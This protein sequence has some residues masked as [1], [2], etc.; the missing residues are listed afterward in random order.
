MFYQLHQLFLTRNGIYLVV[1]NPVRLLRNRK[2]E[3]EGLKFWIGALSIHAPE[4]PIAFIVTRAREVNQ[5]ELKLLDS[6]LCDFCTDHKGLTLVLN[7]QEKL[8]FF[9]VDNSLKRK[10]EKYLAPLKARIHQVVIDE[11]SSGKL[12]GVNVR[13]KLSWIYIMDLFARE[14]K[15]HMLLNEMTYHC[16]RL[17]ITS[18]ELE[19]MLCFYTEVGT[20]IYFPGK[21]KIRT[22]LNEVAVLNPQWLLKALS[23]YIYDSK[24]HKKKKF[25]IKKPYDELLAHYEETGILSRSLLKHLWCNYNKEEVAFLDSLS[26]NM[27]L[28][29]KYVFDAEEVEGAIVD[30]KAYVVPAMLKDYDGEVS[31]VLPDPADSFIASIKFDEP[32]PTG[33]F[34]RFIS[35]FVRKSGQFEGSEEP[36]LYKNYADFGF[37][38]NMVHCVLQKEIK[39]IHIST[40]QKNGEAHMRRVVTFASEVVLRLVD[41]LLGEKFSPR[42]LV[43]AYDENRLVVCE[44]NNLWDVLKSKRKMIVVITQK[45][46]KISVPLETFS[47]FYRNETDI[48]RSTGKYITDHK[49]CVELKEECSGKK[50]E[51]Y[52]FLVHEWGS[53]STGHETHNKV[54][55][56]KE[57]LSRK[58]INL[59]V[60]EAFA[61]VDR[62]Q[63]LLT[64]SNLSKKVVIFLTRRYMERIMDS[65]NDVA[66]QFPYWMNVFPKKDTI[67]IILEESMLNSEIWIGPITDCRS[68]DVCRFDFSTTTRMSRKFRQ[69]SDEFVDVTVLIHESQSNLALLFTWLFEPMQK[70]NCHIQSFDIGKL[71]SCHRAR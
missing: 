7:D 30:A 28:T 44:L 21:N 56:V 57:K 27:L 16:K 50:Y 40:M 58:G 34:E 41:S 47:A 15:S 18:D 19:H 52:V 31:D 9:P 6:I 59:W 55:A 12:H 70:G 38:P 32:M 69:I 64:D 60:H 46:R 14:A 65:E 66:K 11:K 26:A 36:R 13:L 43:E 62:L 67:V 68:E 53:A 8:M 1:L 22:A 3:I 42:I 49:L 51:S 63:E 5:E 25:R 45:G 61:D 71:Q 20:I 33:I 2:E 24:I 23:C 37:G 17:G 48:L 10:N 35:E 29:S 4:A 54:V 39:T